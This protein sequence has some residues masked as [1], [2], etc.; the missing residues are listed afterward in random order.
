MNNEYSNFGEHEPREPRDY[1][2]HFFDWRQVGDC[3]G[4]VPDDSPSDIDDSLPDGTEIVLKDGTTSVQRQPGNEVA[5]PPNIA[6]VLDTDLIPIPDPGATQMF[7]IKGRPDLRVRL[8]EDLPDDEV[9]T[10]IEATNRLMPH[11]V[12]VLPSTV[13]P[14]I[15]EAYVVT[16]EVTGTRLDQLLNPEAPDELI[17]QV[18]R[19]WAGLVKGFTEAQALGRRIP[20]DVTDA[21]QYMYGTLAG[22]AEQNVWLVD[23]PATSFDSNAMSEY[24]VSQYQ[25]EL[26]CAVNA[27]IGIERA[28]GRPLPNARETI[29]RVMEQIPYTDLYTQAF[30]AAASLA[31]RDSVTI[32]PDDVRRQVDQAWQQEN[33]AIQ[34][35][36]TLSTE[37]PP[38]ENGLELPENI[39][40]IIANDLIAATDMPGRDTSKYR[41]R[42]RPDLLV[43]VNEGNTYNDR[44][45]AKQATDHLT[46][47]GINVL[48]S[49]VVEH[50]GESYVITK[51]VDGMPLTEAARQG[52]S[53]ELADAVKVTWEGIVEG[54]IE[55]WQQGLD[56]VSD[57]G[58]PNQFMV[59]TIE[60]DPVPKLWLVD[61][62]H[63]PT[64]LEWG[65]TYEQ[66]VLDAA[67]SIVEAEKQTGISLTSARFSLHYA[68]G[69]CRVVEP[70]GDGLAQ[71]ARYVLEHNKTIS[72]HSGDKH[73]EAL[74]NRLRTL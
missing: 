21:F 36:T 2:D 35:A 69:Q 72:S 53:R 15:G 8:N 60:G 43:R 59:G 40:D 38:V 28:I 67:N 74:I 11:G 56:H 50:E 27:V 10:A 62:P 12:N 14:H 51:M 18:D 58:G 57:I 46:N 61:L 6:E 13:V 3:D 65:D 73:E 55:A 54:L 44:I 66:E 31:L 17:E 16:K 19:T 64:R 24:N 68:L 25:E 39:H 47:H 48:P 42:G 30:T 9:A 33:D 23:L 37:R 71:A 70:Y 63:A 29:R 41:V 7:H 34:D 4:I 32:D 52:I 1:G 45:L 22:E 5:L 26:F 20:G 49:E